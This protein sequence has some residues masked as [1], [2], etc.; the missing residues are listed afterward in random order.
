MPLSEQQLIDCIWPYGEMNCL[1][2]VAVAFEYIQHNNGI[3]TKESYP[4]EGPVSKT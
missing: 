4:Y 2:S 3:D 1:G